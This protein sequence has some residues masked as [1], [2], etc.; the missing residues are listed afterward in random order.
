MVTRTRWRRQAATGAVI[1]TGSLL[2]AAGASFLFTP[3]VQGS[4]PPHTLS[5]ASPTRKTV[6]LLI[7]QTQKDW[8]TRK[9]TVSEALEE[10]KVKLGPEDEAFP[11]LDQLLWDGM[12][13]FLCRVTTKLVAKDEPIPYPTKLVPTPTRYR[14]MPVIRQRGR[15]GLRRRRYQVVYR[16]GRPTERR[17]VSSEVLKPPVGEVITLPPRYQLASRGYYGGR[18]VFKMVATAY[19]PGPGSCG[20]SA[21]GITAM[22]LRAGKGIAAVDPRV[23]PMNARLY[24]ET[25][26]PQLRGMSGRIRHYGHAVAADVGGAIKGNRID[27][28]FSSRAEAMRFGRR[29]VLVYVLD[30]GDARGTRTRP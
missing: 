24:I 4:P 3:V 5:P 12:P 11:D 18:R 22:G 30:G 6:H 19:D 8:V 17:L 10:M 16:D 27:L 14:R 29:E 26:G 25:Y 23:I 15:P 20:A 1:L 7:D 2:A 28:C 9:S 13:I 21:D